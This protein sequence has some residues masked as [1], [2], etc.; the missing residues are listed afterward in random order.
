MS[1]GLIVT[2]SSSTRRNQ[3][4]GFRMSSPPHAHDVARCQ[5]AV[6]F[7]TQTDMLAQDWQ[8]A[9]VDNLAGILHH[10]VYTWMSQYRVCIQ[11]SVSCQ[12]VNRHWRHLSR[13]DAVEKYKWI[14]N[15]QPALSTYGYSHKNM[16]SLIRHL[17]V[18]TGFNIN[19]L[20]TLTFYFQASDQLLVSHN[21]V[22][23]IFVRNWRTQ[24]HVDTTPAF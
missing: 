9:E 12:I 22:S 14:T 11:I 5:F 20:S 3:V 8:N 21:H 2:H 4:T 24:V 16:L 18:C 17:Q 10:R 1:V 19:K 15:W 23:V 7:E 6:S 13:S